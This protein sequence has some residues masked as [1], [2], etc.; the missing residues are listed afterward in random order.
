MRWL[1]QSAGPC[2]GH[3][4]LVAINPG[5]SHAVARHRETQGSRSAGSANSKG[6]LP[7]VGINEL[8]NLRF[9]EKKGVAVCRSI[10]RLYLLQRGPSRCLGGA[11][12]PTA[13]DKGDHL[14]AK[15][16]VGSSL[17]HLQIPE[18]G[19][20]LSAWLYNPSCLSILASIPVPLV[21]PYILKLVHSSQTST[22][23]E[24][25]PSRWT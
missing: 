10:S 13:L 6:C 8:W 7:K 9:P 12:A 4:R 23:Q 24:A 19:G 20:R 16:S 3:L 17:P 22:S 1:W 25:L 15:F 5:L 18:H 2:A 21:V 11:C 14:C